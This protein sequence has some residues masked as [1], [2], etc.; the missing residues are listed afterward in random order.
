MHQRSLDVCRI[1]HTIP[2][3]R[4]GSASA[5]CES[6]SDGHETGWNR[7]G[8]KATPKQLADRIAQNHLVSGKV[9][10]VALM[11]PT[12]I[13]FVCSLILIAVRESSA[14]IVICRPCAS[15]FAD[16]KIENPQFALCEQLAAGG[17]GASVF[18]TPA[19][20]LNI[21]STDAQT[22]TWATET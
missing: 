4:I 10:S 19:S 6:Q 15:G 13:L 12:T 16:L 22:T 17:P 7:H 20:Q 9:L 14:T 18:A 3:I 5:F 8:G 2:V 21:A 11:T 1:L